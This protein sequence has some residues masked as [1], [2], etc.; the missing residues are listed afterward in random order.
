MM[1]TANWSKW[2]AATLRQML[3]VAIMLIASG[4]NE[5]NNIPLDPPLVFENKVKMGTYL[6]LSFMP[7]SLKVTFDLVPVI[8]IFPAPHLHID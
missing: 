7:P 1:R 8:C 3:K 6:D 2:A 5:E 4:K